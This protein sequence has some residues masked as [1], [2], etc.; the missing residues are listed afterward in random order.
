MP[1]PTSSPRS[2][3][4]PSVPHNHDR[5]GRQPYPTEVEDYQQGEATPPGEQGRPEAN[6]RTTR[7][8]TKK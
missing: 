8:R 1:Q 6:P 7:A 3:P 5:E 2:R 4:Q